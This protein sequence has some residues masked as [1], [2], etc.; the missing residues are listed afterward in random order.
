MIEIDVGATRVRLRGAFDEA[1]DK[2]RGPIVLLILG[3][4]SICTERRLF[5]QWCTFNQGDLR[6]IELLAGRAEAGTRAAQQ[7]QFEL[8]DQ[9][10]T[11]HTRV[12]EGRPITR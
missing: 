1:S 2:G 5:I 8:V 12:F 4:A 9:Q 6:V 3:A 7:L 10:S 11:I